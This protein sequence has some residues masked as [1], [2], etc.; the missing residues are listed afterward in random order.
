MQYFSE[1]FVSLRAPPLNNVYNARTDAVNTHI[2]YYLIYQQYYNVLQ[3][4][5]RYCS[6]LQVHQQ[7]KRC[8]QTFLLSRSADNDDDTT[9]AVS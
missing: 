2:F 3:C 1:K 5:C 6:L 7:S 8:M 9:C 4:A